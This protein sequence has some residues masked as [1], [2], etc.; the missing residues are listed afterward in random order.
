[1]YVER[2]NGK[3]VSASRHGNPPATEWISENAQPFKDWLEAQSPAPNYR[4]LREA[5]LIDTISPEGEFTKSAGDALIA[6]TQAVLALVTAVEAGSTTVEPNPVA[7]VNVLL[8]KVLS[9][10]ANYPEPE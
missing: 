5:E 10:R 2:V 8:T 1:M 4:D 9:A 3:I 7:A 6:L